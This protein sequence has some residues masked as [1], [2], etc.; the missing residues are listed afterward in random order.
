M[1][2]KTRFGFLEKLSYKGLVESKIVD[3]IPKAAP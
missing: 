1:F 2:L 3:A